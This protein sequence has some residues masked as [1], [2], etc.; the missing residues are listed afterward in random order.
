MDE[1]GPASQPLAAGLHRRRPSARDDAFAGVAHGL[2]VFRNRRQ[3]GKAQHLRLPGARHRHLPARSRHGA[4][5]AGALFPRLRSHRQAEAPLHPRRHVVLGHRRTGRSSVEHPDSTRHVSS[6]RGPE[7]RA[8]LGTPPSR[9]PRN[10]GDVLLLRN[11]PESVR[12]REHRV[13]RDSQAARDGERR[14]ED[15]A[16]R[17]AKPDRPIRNPGD[18]RQSPDA[19][20]RR[21]RGRRRASDKGRRPRTA[22]DSLEPRREGPRPSKS[23][24]SRCCSN[25]ER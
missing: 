18:S 24:I 13:R 3:S 17:T 16:H 11:R 25:R 10:H 1:G 6:G 12:R 4:P 8:A 7:W 14:R 20:R 19:Q 15:G 2:G 21:P 22:H 5:R 23:R 9:Y